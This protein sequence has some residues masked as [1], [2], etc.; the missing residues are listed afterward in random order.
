MGT[1]PND[2]FIKCVIV[3]ARTTPCDNRGC[4]NTYGI[5]NQRGASAS[6]CCLEVCSTLA[7]LARTGIE[8]TLLYIEFVVLLAYTMH[9]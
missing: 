5:L 2:G 1:A 8:T 9:Y 7:L 6:N 4:N 3:H